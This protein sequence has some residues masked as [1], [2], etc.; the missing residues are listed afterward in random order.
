VSDAARKFIVQ[1]P[2]YSLDLRGAAVYF[3]L[4]EKTLRNW[5]YAGKLRRGTEYIK[6]GAKVLIIRDAFET[7]LRSDDGSI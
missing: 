5:I 2:P 6:S 1:H 4:A 3:G 7:F